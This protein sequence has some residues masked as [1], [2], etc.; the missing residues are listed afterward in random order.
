MKIDP[1]ASEGIV[2]LGVTL[3]VCVYPS[4]LYHVSTAR[5]ISLGGEGNALYP[6]LS[7]LIHTIFNYRALDAA[8]YLADSGAKCL[9]ARLAVQLISA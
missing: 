5:R 9:T 6:V 4:R 1:L 3:C 2:A 7:S 8:H